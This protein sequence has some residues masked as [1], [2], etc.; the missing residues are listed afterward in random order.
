MFNR[1]ESDKVRFLKAY[2]EA[3]RGVTSLLKAINAAR[4]AHGESVER[5][6]GS[7]S[8]LARNPA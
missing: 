3:K 1:Y 7:R 2:P 8:R 6:K 4:V 5:P